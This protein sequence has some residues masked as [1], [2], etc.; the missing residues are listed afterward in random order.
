MIDPALGEGLIPIKLKLTIE[1]DAI[2]YDLSGS[3]PTISTF[4]NAAFGYCLGCEMFLL[5]QRSPLF[6][7]L[8]RSLRNEKEVSA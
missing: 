8:F 1:G 2:K 3:H 7:P 4:L 5:V 6:R